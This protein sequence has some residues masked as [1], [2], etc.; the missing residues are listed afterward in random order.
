MNNCKKTDDN[1]DEECPWWNPKCWNWCTILLVLALAAIAAA[2]VLIITGACISDPITMSIG[3]ATAVLGLVL[4]TLWFLLCSKVQTSFCEALND[5]IDIFAW[6]VSIQSVVLVILA[7][8]GLFPG[9][10]IGV[11]ITWG[12]YGTILG[13]LHLIKNWTDC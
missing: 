13:Y 10:L 4:L 1:G 2:A 3:F 8:T 12:Y 5:L 6:I 11:L 7:I 9:G